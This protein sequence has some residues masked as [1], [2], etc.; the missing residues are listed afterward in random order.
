MENKKALH[1]KKCMKGCTQLLDPLRLS[2]TPFIA[3]I[4]NGSGRSSD[5]RIDLLSAPSRLT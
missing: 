4:T 5:F 3:G 2:F 1:A